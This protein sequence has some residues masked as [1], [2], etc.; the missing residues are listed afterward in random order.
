MLHFIS[1]ASSGVKIEGEKKQLVVTDKLK[2]CR[3]LKWKRLLIK[4]SLKEMVSLLRSRPVKAFWVNA[5]NSEQTSV[6]RIFGW[7]KRNSAGLFA[8]L[9]ILVT[10]HP[11]CLL[12]CLLTSGLYVLYCIFRVVS[13]SATFEIPVLFL[14]PHF[15]FSFDPLLKTDWYASEKSFCY[16]NWN[17]RHQNFSC[18]FVFLAPDKNEEPA[19]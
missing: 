10:G 13:F 8:K 18:S 7:D 2:Q 4:S 12:F 17:W 11:P 19:F 1:L 15:P 16:W 9:L 5:A 3:L 6:T 14:L